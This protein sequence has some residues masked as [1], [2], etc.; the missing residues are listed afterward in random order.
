MA[1][2]PMM[3]QY[4]D[5]REKYPDTIIFF[6]LGDFYEMFFEQAQL[7][8]RE[9]ELT[10]TGKDCGLEER[11]PMCGVPFH[12]ASSYIAKLVE[13]G[14][15]VGMCEQVE[16][17]KEAKGLV[18]RDVVKVITP[19]TIM[20]NTMLEETINNYIANIYLVGSEYGVSYTDISTGEC[21]VTH[22]SGVT[23]PYQVIDE[24][25]KIN[26][27]ELVLEDNIL[28]NSIIMEN[29]VKRNN[30]YV[31]RYL[32]QDE[33]TIDQLNILSDEYTLSEKKSLVLLLNYILETQKNTANQINNIN[34][35]NI[36][37]YMR[38][39]K[40]TR[41]NLEI[42]ESSRE[43]TKKGSILWVLD[44]TITAIGS[45]QIRR[46]IENPLVSKM[47][48]Q[49]RLSLVEVLKDDIFAREDLQELLNH[50][51][52][53]ERLIARVSSGT[54]NG[55]DL[56][57]L[58][59]SFK[60]IP[61]IKNKLLVLCKNVNKDKSEYLE[62]IYNNLDELKDLYKIIEKSI[63]DEPP[64]T[65]KEGAVIKD[66][67][68]AEVDELRSSSRDG[69]TWIMELEASEKKITGIKGLK[70]GFNR[71]F[72]YYIEV[73]K[74]NFQDV[75]QDRYIRKQT[76]IDK[77]RY[78]TEELKE[79]ESKILGSEE[80]LLELEYKLFNQIREQ[81]SKEIIRV[82]KTAEMIGILDC[83]CSFAKVAE[84]SNYVKPIITEDGAISIKDGRHPV[85]EKTLTLNAFIPNDTYIDNDSNRF[86]IITG[87]NMAGKSTY[88][89]QVAVITYMAQ[90]GSFVPASEAKISIVDRIF[91]RVGASDDL[92]GGE[93]TFMVEMTELSNILE[94]ATKNSLVIL[95]E[96][97]RGTSTYDGMAIAW[98]TVEYIADLNK[99]GA[100]TLF[101]T[102]YHELKELEAKIQGVKN[103]SVKVKEKGD[104]VIFLRKI[105]EGPADE[106]YGIYVAKLAGIP[107]L[108]VNRAKKI[109]EKLEEQNISSKIKQNTTK[110]VEDNMQVDMFNYKLAEVGKILDKMSLDELTAKDALD[111]LYKLK[112]KLK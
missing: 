11:A 26:P 83:L 80:K 5:I 49:Q 40:S 97:G 4:L 14:Y 112:D 82:Q 64:I 45:R 50:V 90:I 3:Q 18:K 32:N 19:G 93:S 27:R 81:I 72:G 67:Y 104:E 53:I 47:E 78:I 51:Y 6:R 57:S 73:T 71:V 52:D 17:P 106:S 41:R 56:I 77:E 99:I 68:N 108:V 111:T 55:R 88:M 22:A 39:D 69:K 89:R 62:M 46:W 75:P 9:L 13:K 110:V 29:I 95:D 23:A 70:V 109:L 61:D 105:I 43:K 24:V 103:F 100:K 38:L 16:D 91:T 92:A 65:I 25:L 8:S 96:I 12:S 15:K 54:T 2:S 7:C 1:I 85:V 86:Q 84:D 35:Y 79:I 28:N 37:N 48:I 34:K 20:E 87:P 36:L 60:V 59:N 98:A 101:A 21:F 44:K 102:H 74:S 76:L 94:N 63:A 30:I 58:K 66:G 107:N 42:S 10:L 31:S 33:K